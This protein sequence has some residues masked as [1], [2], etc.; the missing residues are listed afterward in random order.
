[1]AATRR[2]MIGAALAVPPLVAARRGRAQ[3]WPARPIRCIVP[4]VTGGFDIY[5]RIVAARLTERLGQPVVVD[6]RPGANGNI[7]MAE[8]ARA[9]PDGHTILFAAVGSLS[10]NISVFRTMPFDPIE[11]L[12][13]LALSVTSPMVWVANP[14]APFTTLP[15]LVREARRAPGRIAYALPSSGTINHLIVEGFKLRH[16]LDMPA[17]PYRGTPPAQT[18]VIAGQVPVMVDSVGAGSGHIADGRLR[19]LAVT[20]RERAAKLPDV[21]TVIELGLED[22]DYLAWYAF[23]APRGT[24]G[25]VVG[26][27]NAEINAIIAEP[28]TVARLQTLG[29]DPRAMTPDAQAAFMRAEREKWGAIARAA[30]VEAV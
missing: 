9:A 1:M 20:T 17:V 27:L 15:E 4:S 7:G 18:D 25:E 16:D 14:A 23:M 3:A 22:R 30:K 19:A 24:P 10:I 2:G 5:A 8:V 12:Q 21:P 13:P 6:N 29:A 11:A 28:A 26:R